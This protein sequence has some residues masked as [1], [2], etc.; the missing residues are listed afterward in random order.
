MYRINVEGGKDIQFT[1]G[2]LTNPDTWQKWNNSNGKDKSIADRITK[3]KRW[4]NDTKKEILDNPGTV[5]YLGI[6]KDDISFSR[7]TRLKKVPGQTWNLDQVRSA[8]PNA[9]I[10][11]MYLYSGNGGTAMVSKSVQGK[12]VVFATS[13]KHLKIDGEKVTESNLADMYLKMQRRRKEVYDQ[14]RA[15][16]LDDK[17]AKAEVAEQ[18]PPLIRMIVANSNGAFINEY[19]RL[20]FNDMVHTAD[21]GSTKL[22]R[23]QVKE[24]L[25]TFG[26]NTTAARMLVAMWNYRSGLSN[27]VNAYESYK[28][29][30]DKVDIEVQQSD[31]TTGMTSAID[32][33][34]DIGMASRDL[35]DSETEAGLTA[36]VIAKDGIA[37]IVNNDSG[38]AELTSDQVKD[39]YTGNITTWEDL[40]K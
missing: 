34:C 12:G 6:E 13:N 29:V 36:T 30:N 31:S 4:Y 5:K 38:V 1:V 35:K 23:D 10:S 3:Y 21:D 14:A 39:I 22:D 18:V 9:I 2:K 25:G 33:L 19:F 40:A 26:S 8:F 28:E 27:F 16:G 7:A 15:R 20:S 24:Y 37:I 32:G 11:P 17:A